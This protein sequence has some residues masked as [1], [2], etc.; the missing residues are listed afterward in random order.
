[1][2]FAKHNTFTPS[3]APF[4]NWKYGPEWLKWEFPTLSHEH[5]IEVVEILEAFHTPG[6]LS[7]RLE[8]TKD[9]MGLVCYQPN[10]VSQQFR[11]GQLLPKSYFSRKSELCMSTVEMIEANYNEILNRQSNMF[12]DL[13]FFSILNILLLHSRV[14]HLVEN[15]PCWAICSYVKFDEFSNKIFFLSAEQVC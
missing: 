11:F 8:N 10:L 12:L 15:V 13:T 7:S 1:M 4:V 3:L 6:L 14:R 9:T 5:E 2:M